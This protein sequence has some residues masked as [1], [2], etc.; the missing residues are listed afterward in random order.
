V[1][2][3]YIVGN[4][5]EAIVLVRDAIRDGL[6]RLATRRDARLT[7]SYGQLEVIAKPPVAETP[8]ARYRR[9]WQ[10]WQISASMSVTKS[11]ALTYSSGVAAFMTWC[12]S[13]DVDPT[14]KVV[15][16]AYDPQIAVFEHRITSFLNFLGYLAYDLGL[17]PKTVN[18][19]KCAVI[20]FFRGRLVDFSFIQHAA[21]A[22]LRAS[23]E[24]HWNAFHE[25]AKKRRLPFTLEMRAAM[26][27]STLDLRLA[28]DRSVLITTEISLV[29]M[30][31]QSELI[32]T[33]DNHFL[34]EDDVHFTFKVTAGGPDVSRP[35]RLALRY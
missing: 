24:V 6:A 26:V 21:V 9:H 23:L 1:Y 31:R 28:K 17:D 2:Y 27:R 30:S 34:R 10:N 25:R 15:P 18:V 3:V 5:F 14:F 32:P 16:Y 29:L 11:T 8:D 7:A 22:Q 35:S 13:C 33:A 4:P 20:N 12:M 19:Y